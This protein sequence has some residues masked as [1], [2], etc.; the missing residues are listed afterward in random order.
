MKM[1]KSSF[2]KYQVVQFGVVAFI[3]LFTVGVVVLAAMCI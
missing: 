3:V 1:D 2:R